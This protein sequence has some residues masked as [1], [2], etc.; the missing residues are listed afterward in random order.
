MQKQLITVCFYIIFPFVLYGQIINQ[1]DAAGLKQ[2]YWEA[3]DI[4]GMPVYKGYFK[5]D[6]PVGK[7]TRYFPTGEVRV[8]M[9]YDDKSVMARTQFFWHNGTVAAKGV[10]INTKR[11]SVWLFYNQNGTL[12]SRVEY[13]SGKR[14]GVERK[15][16]MEGN[17][18]AEEI[19]WKDSIKHGAWNQ[20][21]QSGQL[22]FTVT[23]I[24][25]KLEGQ[26]VS[27]YPDGKKEVEG[28]YRNGTPDGEWKR[29][30]ENGEY[31]ST[32]KFDRGTITNMEEVEED[33]HMFFRKATD[34]EEYLPERTLED[35]F[36]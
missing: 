21:F 30:H 24:D 20:Y 26:Y 10:Y 19:N 17:D 3:E 13:S 12:S 25:G 28:M 22:K 5:D 29:Y 36:R 34:L 33:E 9:D 27:W 23:Y 16:Y 1:R 7:M 11:D 6:K 18:I 35:L 15:F 14:H 31:I 8:I 4:S 32:I 2:G